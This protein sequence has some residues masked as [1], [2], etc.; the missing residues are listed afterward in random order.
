MFPARAADIRGDESHDRFLSVSP[1]LINRTRGAHHDRDLHLDIFSSLDGFGSVNGGDWGGYWGKQGPE[2][3]DHRLASFE[4]E[5][6]M[7]FG[8]N[9]IRQFVRMLASSTEESDVR[10]RWVTRMRNMPA[11]VVSTTLGR[12]SRLA[13][14][15]RRRR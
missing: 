6:R 3:L 1:H 9:T 13:G 11:T 8:A 12:P 15:D 7:V 2:L 10:D 14:R 4:A 5:Q